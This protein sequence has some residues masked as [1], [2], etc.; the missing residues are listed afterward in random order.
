MRCILVIIILIMARLPFYSQSGDTLK[1]FFSGFQ[2]HFGFIIPH[3]QKIEQISG[4]RPFGFGIN[5]GRVDKSFKGRSIFNRYLISGFEAAYFNFRNPRIIGSAFLLTAFAEPVLSH[6]NEFFFSLRGGAGISLHT[7]IYDPT[8]NPLA[9]FFGTRINFPLYVSARFNYRLSRFMLINLSGNY[10]HIS[11]G[12]IKQPNLGMNFP[13]MSLGLFYFPHSIPALT[14]L[15]PVA[16]K[17]EKPGILVNIQMITGYKVVDRTEVYPQKGA[18]VWGIHLRAAKQL[19]QF[20]ALGAGAELIMDRSLK[21]NISREYLNMDYRRAALTAG[22]DFF[23]G[24]VIF[25]QHFGFYIYAPYKARNLLYQKY[26]LSY[27]IKPHLLS[28]V[29]LKAHSQVADLMGLSFTYRIATDGR[30]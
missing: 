6:G 22:Q 19:R 25:S 29:Y 18:F 12:G 16:E 23:L 1:Y 9:L 4:T 2:S 24:N 26:E 27:K 8:D 13:T 5:A 10:N 30:K 7:K 15:N 14:K 17:V 20:Y 28:G 21:E 11:N 3:S